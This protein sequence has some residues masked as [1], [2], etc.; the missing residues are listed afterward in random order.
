MVM[1]NTMITNSQ[2][3]ASLDRL[4]TG[5]VIKDPNYDQ[6]CETYLMGNHI[7]ICNHH[8][9]KLSDSEIKLLGAIVKSPMLPS[10]EYIKLAHISP[11]TLSKIRDNLLEQDYIKEN[12][13]SNTRGR[14]AK[15]WEPTEKAIDIMSKIEGQNER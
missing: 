2:A 10:A 6:I 4:V 13:V 15:I 5:E 1:K 9:H 8:P 7:A 11:N 14:P 3:D 12:L